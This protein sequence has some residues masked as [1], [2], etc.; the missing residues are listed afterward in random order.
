MDQYLK[1]LNSHLQT[2]RIG[3]LKSTAKATSS[4]KLVVWDKKVALLIIRGEKH[5]GSYIK[6]FLQ[7]P[8]YAGTKYPWVSSHRDLFPENYWEE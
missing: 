4:G 3:E 2:Y 6:N 5:W 8:Y 1:I 7:F